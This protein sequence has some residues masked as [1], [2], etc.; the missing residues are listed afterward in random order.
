MIPAF[1]V[2][3]RTGASSMLGEDGESWRMDS[4]EP[5][6]TYQSSWLIP[7]FLSR[8]LEVQNVFGSS[9]ALMYLKGTEQRCIQRTWTPHT[10]TG[11]QCQSYQMPECGTAVSWQ[12]WTE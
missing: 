1:Q 10:L 3:C 5:F 6:L 7:V 2:G 9:E 8:T 4:G 12:R 11:C